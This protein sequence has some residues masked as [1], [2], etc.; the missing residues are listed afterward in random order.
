MPPKTDNIPSASDGTAEL[1]SFVQGL[2]QQM[3][4]RFEEMSNNIISRID[5]MGTRID[6]LEKSIDE[7][8]QQAGTEE[9]DTPKAKGK[10]K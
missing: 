7:L 9:E 1:T 5:D 8:M 4:S 10:K 2:L 3:Q 6:D